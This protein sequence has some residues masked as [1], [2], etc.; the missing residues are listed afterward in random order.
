MR[1]KCIRTLSDYCA[2]LKQ[3][4]IDETN[5]I[6]FISINKESEN[7]VLTIS[8]HLDWSNPTDHLVSLQSKIN[9]YLE[10]I[11]SEQISSEYTD[12]INRQLE[13]SVVSKYE[14]PE[15]VKQENLANIEL[16]LSNYNLKFNWRKK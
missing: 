16:E 12:S 3:M 11:E 8:D 7:C 4:A 10:F 13:I 6:D 9:S 14:I 1:I 2:Q 15:S 5:K